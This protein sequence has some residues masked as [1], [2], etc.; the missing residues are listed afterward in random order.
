MLCDIPSCC[1]RTVFVS[2]APSS[3]V[4][5]YEDVLSLCVADIIIRDFGGSSFNDHW[6][7]RVL[8]IFPL[9]TDHQLSCSPKF[10][11]SIIVR[12]TILQ[13]RLCYLCET[14]C[15]TDFLCNHCNLVYCLCGNI[16]MHLVIMHFLSATY[17]LEQRQLYYWE[18]NII[19]FKFL[20]N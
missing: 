2:S 3:F 12:I 14:C 4:C 13:N 18:S 5:N 9:K 10:H 8:W 20:N 15:T 6:A 19:L 7:V 1:L 16:I 11:G 17:W